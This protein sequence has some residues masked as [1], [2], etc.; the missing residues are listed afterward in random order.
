MFAANSKNEIKKFCD[1]LVKATFVKLYVF[2]GLSSTDL[3]AYCTAYCINVLAYN[4]FWR[5]SY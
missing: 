5:N 4:Q 1:N 3:L 2:L